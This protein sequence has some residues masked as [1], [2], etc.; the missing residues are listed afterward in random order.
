M[1]YLPSKDD[2][3]CLR[4]VEQHRR[5]TEVYADTISCMHVH[6]IKWLRSFSS[7]LFLPY[8]ESCPV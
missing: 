7:Y 6:T 3:F 1:Y 8:A 2:H 5:C 4:C